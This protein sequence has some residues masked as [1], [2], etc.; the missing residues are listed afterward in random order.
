[1]AKTRGEKAPRLY[2]EAL[3]AFDILKAEAQFRRGRSVLAWTNQAGEPIGYIR[4]DQIARHHATFVQGF[5]GIEGGDKATGVVQLA[6]SRRL[7]AKTHDRPAILCP[8]CGRAVIRVHLR[9]W[10]WKCRTCHDLCHLSQRAPWIVLIMH[11]RALLVRKLKGG[12]ARYQR[13]AQFEKDQRRFAEVER[14]LLN[15]GGY[16]PDP[17]LLLR[18]DAEWLD[19][20]AALPAAFSAMKAAVPPAPVTGAPSVTTSAMATP[21]REAAPSRKVGAPARQLI[22]PLFDDPDE[23]PEEMRGKW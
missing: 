7:Q 19:D 20:E 1:M 8:G 10:A 23:W 12:R 6:L 22:T 5:P 4:I 17:R 9:G 21:P 16:E 14:A 15:M 18:A 2:V 13:K 3:P 11:E